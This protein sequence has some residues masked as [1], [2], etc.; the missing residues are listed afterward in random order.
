MTDPS[1][2]GDDDALRKAPRPPQSPAPSEVSSRT[3][4][5]LIYRV[6][7][8]MGRLRPVRTIID[9]QHRVDSSEDRQVHPPL[10]SGLQ[11]MATS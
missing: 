2:W 3:V 6:N 8:P 7:G 9:R 11:E 5:L 10:A 1:L 4:W